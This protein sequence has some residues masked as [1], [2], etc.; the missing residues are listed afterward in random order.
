MGHAEDIVRAREHTAGAAQRENEAQA[1]RDL[2]AREGDDLTRIRALVPRITAAMARDE[3]AW[4]QLVHFERKTLFGGFKN[5]QVAGA[6][7]CTFGYQ[8]H[9]E[10]A[11]GTIHLLRDGRF[12]SAARGASVMDLSAAH[13][14]ANYSRHGVRI[15]GAATMNLRAIADGLQALADRHEA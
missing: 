2:L 9:G 12:V 6:Q 10:P 13:E 4:A 14:A 5:T 7:V 11:T 3:Y 8:V 1:R 15:S